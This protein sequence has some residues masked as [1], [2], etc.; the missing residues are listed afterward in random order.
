MEKEKTI[1]AQDK[2]YSSEPGIGNESM[3]SGLP[4]APQSAQSDKLYPK[5][6]FEM[7]FYT[8]LSRARD[9]AE[10][11]QQ[12]L[13]VVNRLGFSDFAF[14]R[15]ENIVGELSLGEGDKLFTNPKE[16]VDIY[17]R[18]GL[19]EQDLQIAYA[20]E[21]TIPVFMSDIYGYAC[22][23]PF[24]TEFLRRNQQIYALCQRFGYFDYYC[25]PMQACCYKG[26]VLFGVSQRNL[27]TVEFKAK[28][29]PC[30]LTLKLLGEAID[31]IGTVKFSD[32][33][34][35]QGQE[36]APAV[37][38][39]SR[40]LQVLNT[41][42]NQDMGTRQVADRLGI[43]VD[44]V[45]QHLAIARKALR[46]KTTIGAIKNAVLAGLIDYKK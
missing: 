37:N 2:P 8:E 39:R 26:K 19:Y 17:C 36:D 16:Q 40:P 18:E 27:N 7:G 35:G 6:A 14:L 12:I 25:I 4:S 23:A 21:N 45:N 20:R 31:H 5:Q 33:V 3:P 46:A 34:I 11:K 32:F 24:Q 44:T 22:E 13:A 43:S 38:I 10:F 30:K 42:A 41:L 28:I 29:A 9:I 1:N 15:L